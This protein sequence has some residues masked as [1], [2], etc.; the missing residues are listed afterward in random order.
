MFRTPNYNIYHIPH[1]DDRA[2][3]GTAVIIHSA[4]SHHE[5]IHHQNKKFQAAR[6]KV[7]LKPWSLSLS[8]VYCPH[9]IPSNA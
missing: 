6:V 2:H 3:G 5:F 1:P 8:A 9:D 4:I 7:D